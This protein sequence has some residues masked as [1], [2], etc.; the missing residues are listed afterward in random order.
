MFRKELG[1]CSFQ[2]IKSSI[3]SVPGKKTVSISVLIEITVVYTDTHLKKYTD[4]NIK[5]VLL[6]I[7]GYILL[8]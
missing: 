6:L 2:E 8:Y 5:K 3:Y 1:L 4:S 7:K